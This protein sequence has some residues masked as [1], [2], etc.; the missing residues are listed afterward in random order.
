[1]SVPGDDITTRLM[2]HP[3]ALTSEEIVQQLVTLF[4]AATEPMA[5]WLGNT[6]LLVLTD[7]RFSDGPGGGCRPITDAIDEVLIG[8]PPLAVHGITYPRQPVVLVGV[9]L[10]ADQ[11]VAI[12]MTACNNDPAVS[13]GRKDVGGKWHLAWLDGS[14][15]RVLHLRARDRPRGRGDRPGVAERPTRRHASGRS[16]P[17]RAE[18][19]SVPPRLERASRRIHPHSTRGRMRHLMTL[20]HLPARFDL[21]AAFGHPF[22]DAQLATV[23]LT[24]RQALTLCDV[25]SVPLADLDH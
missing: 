9:W 11:P 5:N 21:V 19:G 20:D 17:A 18:A 13:Q 10:P 25:I 8:D 16:R 4:A 15:P 24:L 2:A 3:A 7:A 12:S 6:Q 23:D 22:L 1:M 14:P